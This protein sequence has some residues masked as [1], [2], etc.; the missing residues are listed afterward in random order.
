MLSDEICTPRSPNPELVGPALEMT[1]EL[2]SVSERAL[3]PFRGVA[4]TPVLDDGAEGRAAGINERCL[5]LNLYG[6]GHLTN[7]ESDVDRRILSDLQDDAGAKRPL[8]SRGTGRHGVFADREIGGVI[9]TGF[10]RFR[11]LNA[12]LVPTLRTLRLPGDDR[13]LR[14]GD[15]TSD[16]SCG[17]LSPGQDG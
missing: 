16:R 7:V 11:F 3:R 5:C 10:I 17:L 4:D 1:P 15:R 2:R 12:A 14:V 6:F 8:E 9:E 13:V